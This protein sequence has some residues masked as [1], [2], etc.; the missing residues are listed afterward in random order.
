MDLVPA[1]VLQLCG[2]YLVDMILPTI[3]V[4]SQRAKRVELLYIQNL[5]SFVIAIEYWT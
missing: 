1:E 4:V 5:A 2:R 3:W